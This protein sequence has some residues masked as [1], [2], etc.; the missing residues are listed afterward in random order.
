LKL[1]FQNIEIQ[2]TFEIKQYGVFDDSLYDFQPFKIK[3]NPV[4]LSHRC[5]YKFPTLKTKLSECDFFTIRKMK[6]HCASLGLS[7]GHY[8]YAGMNSVHCITLKEVTDAD[9]TILKKYKSQ[10]WKKW[11][12]VESWLLSIKQFIS[13]E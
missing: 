5:P 7:W 2:T 11:S 13:V 4:L 3:I 10:S 12:Q 9:R 6:P 1:S 8:L